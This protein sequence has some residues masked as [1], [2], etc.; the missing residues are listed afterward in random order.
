MNLGQRIA[1]VGGRVTESGTVEFGSVMAVEALV[2]H[3]LRDLAP[4]AATQD[5]C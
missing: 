3:V 4:G 1:H 5:T 2:I